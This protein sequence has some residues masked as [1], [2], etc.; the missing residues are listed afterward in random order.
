MGVDEVPASVEVRPIGVVRSTRSEAVDDG[1]DAETSRIE[2]LPPLDERALLGI[3]DFSHCTVV[4]LFHLADPEAWRMSR[5]PRG[6]EAWPEVGILAQRAKDRPNRIGV[7]TCRVLGREG[8]TLRVAGL[9]AVDGTPVLDVKP[10]MVE[11]GPRGDVHQP[12]WAG[13]LMQRYW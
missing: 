2:L 5:H 12:E 7:T 13:E 6:N 10:H 8:S 11:F 3:E 9:D 4:Y 1:W